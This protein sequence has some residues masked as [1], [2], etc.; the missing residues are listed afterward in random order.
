MILVKNE[1]INVTFLK[2][3]DVY[4]GLGTP[5]LAQNGHF[6]PKYMDKN[7]KDYQRCF[8]KPG[9]GLKMILVK[10]EENFQS[11]PQ[12]SSLYQLF[13]LLACCQPLHLISHLSYIH[14]LS[15]HLPFFG[16]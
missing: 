9:I 5:F 10:N 13:L 16:S 4:F 2:V 6:W 3:S 7:S 15:S 12:T 11:S 8:T 1:D 14:S